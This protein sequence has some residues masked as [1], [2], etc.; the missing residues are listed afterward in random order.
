[1]SCPFDLAVFLIKVFTAINLL[2]RTYFIASISFGM[3][4]RYC[5]FVDTVLISTISSVTHWWFRMVLLNFHVFMYF[6]W[7]VLSLVSS[8][9]ALWSDIYGIISVPLCLLKHALRASTRILGEHL[10]CS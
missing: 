5:F 8:F 9:I 6:L 1:M 10:T 7:L 4:W 2:Y 3:Y